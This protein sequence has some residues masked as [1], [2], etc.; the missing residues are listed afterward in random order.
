MDYYRLTIGR[1]VY[2]KLDAIG[3]HRNR[4]LE[5]GQR[6]FGRHGGCAPMPNYQGGL[7]IA[8]SFSF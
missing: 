4:H 6:V 5:S 3:S 2:V 1:Q 8:G 7:M